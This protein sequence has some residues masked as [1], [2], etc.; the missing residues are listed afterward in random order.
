M[1]KSLYQYL[2]VNGV[3][4]NLNQF[5]DHF[6]IT[7]QTFRNYYKQDT[8]IIDAYIKQWRKDNDNW[9]GL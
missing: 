4:I 6:K 9:L 1:S 8:R 7:T 2:K 5:A 3:T